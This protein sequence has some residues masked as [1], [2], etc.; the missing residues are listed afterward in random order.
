[1]SQQ[2]SKPGNAVAIFFF[3]KLSLDVFSE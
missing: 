2:T 1:M 3:R